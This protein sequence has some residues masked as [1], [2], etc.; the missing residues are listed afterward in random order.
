MANIFQLLQ[1]AA[2]GHMTIH[3]DDILKFDFAKVLQDGAHYQT[4]ES[5]G[6][7]NKHSKIYCGSCYRKC[8]SK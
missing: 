8:P 6:E 7:L 3:H 1:D 5:E 2:D 4:W